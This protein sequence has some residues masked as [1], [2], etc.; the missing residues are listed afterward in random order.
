MLRIILFLVLMVAPARA[1]IE[2]QIAATQATLDSLNFLL[3]ADGS[4]RRVA[5]VNSDTLEDGS[6]VFNTAVKALGLT[7]EADKIDSMWVRVIIPTSTATG[8]D[9]T[10]LKSIREDFIAKG[11]RVVNGD[12][13]RTSYGR[14]RGLALRLN[15]LVE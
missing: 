6:L 13:L 4:D 8:S 10:L 12:T 3:I 9:K 5:A 14:W 15:K 11:S 1:T 2:D 7:V